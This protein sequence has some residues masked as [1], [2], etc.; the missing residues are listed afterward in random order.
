MQR[1]N[2]RRKKGIY[3]QENFIYTDVSTRKIRTSG[4]KIYKL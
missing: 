3:L 4:I 2:F 1:L